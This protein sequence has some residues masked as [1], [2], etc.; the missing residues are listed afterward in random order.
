[1]VW[2]ASRGFLSENLTSVCASRVCVSVQ[3]H[4]PH[5]E[6]CVRPICK[7]K[8]FKMDC[9]VRFQQTAS[10]GTHQ[11]SLMTGWFSL[12]STTLDG[13]SRLSRAPNPDHTRRSTT[14]WLLCVP[15]LQSWQSLDGLHS[16]CV[17]IF[18]S[19][20]FLAHSHMVLNNHVQRALCA[21]VCQGTGPHHVQCQIP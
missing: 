18:K 17:N 16:P 20:S 19:G 8:A 9:I 14:I 5:G 6:M 2:V 3:R 7:P 13:N 15:D 21:H 11:L 10:S 1:M 4:G 12:Q